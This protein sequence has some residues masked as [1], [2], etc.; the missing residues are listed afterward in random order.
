MSLNVKVGSFTSSGLTG[1]QDVTGLGFD[2]TALV[3]FWWNLA[4]ADGIGADFVWGFGVGVS[5]TDRRASG[6]YANDNFVD[7]RNH[8][9]NQN[10]SC[11]YGPG[12]SPRADY[13]GAITDGFRI[14]WIAASNTIINYLAI[15][16]SDLTNAM[17]GTLTS[18]TTGGTFNVTGVGF[19]GTCLIAFAGKYSTDNLDQQTNGAAMI[20]LATSAGSQGY[21]AWRSRNLSNPQV[22]KHRQSK[23]NVIVSLTDIGIFAEAAFV[24][25][26]SDG[27]T[28]NFTTAPTSADVLYYLV[29]R[30]PRFK[31]SNFIQPTSTGNQG[32]TGAG[33]RPKASL[34][35][36]A[37]DTAANDDATQAN[38][39]MSLGAATGTTARGCMWAGDVNGVSPTQ[40]DHDLD[41]TKLLKLIAPGSGTVNAAADHVSFD[42]DG[43]T[44]N[45]T[46]ADATQREVLVLWIGEAS[47]SSSSSLR[48]NSLR[49]RIFAP[50]IAR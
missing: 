20:G 37:N 28:L 42:T 2:D 49:P 1:N 29:L 17:C 21:V 5:S 22:A 43:Q 13:V 12:A 26:T 50:G 36:S 33:F 6:N 16:G 23:S 41:R 34:M 14:N 35:I 9:W 48:F 10:A 46:S 44:I 3:I 39:Q 11:I 7:S 8:A 40:T 27:F 45:W 47:S 24:G 30:G 38:A 15:G 25:F 18:P 19:E 32:L 31:V 4:T